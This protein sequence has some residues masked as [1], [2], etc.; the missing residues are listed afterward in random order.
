M[1]EQTIAAISTPIGTGGIGIIRLSGEDAFEIA[2]KLFRGKKKVVDMH[3][4]TIEYG[5]IVND[6]G[7]IV[8]RVL[9]SKMDGP[10]TF[11]GEDTVEINCHGGLE[12]IQRILSMVYDAG[13]YPA[14]PGEYTQRAFL[15][16]K[17][18]LAQAEAVVD[19][20]NSK[21]E[22][23]TKE[24]VKQLE[25]VLSERIKD[26]RGIMVK[27]V[28]HLEAE[29]DYPEHQIEEVSRK[30]VLDDLTNT[31]EKLVNL[32]KGFERGRILKNGIKIIIVGSPNV[33]KSS[34]LNSL[35][36]KER[37]IVSNIPG[38]TRDTIEEEYSIN[39]IS[40][41]FTDTAGIRQT[42]DMIEQIGVDRS[43]KEMNMGDI[44]LV[45]MDLSEKIDTDILDAITEN[46]ETPLIFALNKNDLLSKEETEKKKKEIIEE[47]DKRI[48][49]E[50]SVIE[51]SAKENEG[52][53][54]LRD[55]IEKNIFSGKDFG[56][57]E[58]I[59]TNERHKKLIDDAIISVDKALTTVDAMLPL[60]LCILDIRDAIIQLGKITGEDVDS[61]ILHEIFSRF[62]IGK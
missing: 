56:K 23:S 11:T 47:I 50:Y 21:S 22:K 52:I 48:K 1:K 38:T 3:T 30:R 31:R 29:V 27:L 43:F 28:A 36:E 61:D 53:E 19:I 8:D 7:E 24:A 62:C 35:V 51:V 60:D 13:A 25:G 9:L 42:E 40:V 33:G 10:E 4:H 16:G 46:E 14:Q 5:K 17:L 18:D 58:A 55:L 6:E 59:L 26:V 54:E 41:M 32:S 37:A 34:L 15:N 12:I 45:V 39:G 44:I 57:D 49:R 20:I 2:D